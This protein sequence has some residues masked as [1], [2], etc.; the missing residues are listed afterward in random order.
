MT[1]LDKKEKNIKMLK[2]IMVIFFIFVICLSN[3]FG[4]TYSNLDEI[5]N[6]NFARN[7]ANGLI[8]YKD[9]NMIQTPLLS[10]ICGGF[11]KIFGQEIIVMRI[12]ATIVLT[13]IFFLAFKILKKVTN[14]KIALLGVMMFLFLFK[15]ILCIDYNYAVLL[16]ALILVY[17]EILQKEDYFFKHRFKYD[18]IIGMIAGIAVLF[19]Q[20]TGIAVF[21]ACIGYKIFKIRK[22]EEIQDFFKIAI[23]RLIGGLIP[24]IGFV[25]YLVLNEALEDFINYAI[26]GTTTFSN[27]ILYKNLFGQGIISW[28]ALF[29][30]ITIFSMFIIM[31]MKNT[32]REVYIFFAYGI[33][34][35]IVIYPISDK[36][37]FCIGG[38]ITF[39]A[40]IYILFDLIYSE[41]MFSSWNS[42]VRVG[43]Y[44]IFSFAVMFV[45]LTN[46][47]GALKIFD[48]KYIKVNKEKELTHFK[49]IPESIDLK[50]RIFEIND[51]IKEKKELGKN[52]YVLDA[53]AAIYMIPFDRYN[54]NYDMFLKG[55]LGKDGEKGIIEKIKKEENNIYLIKKGNRNW[56]TPNEVC[57]YV[58]ENCEYIGDISIFWSFQK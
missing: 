33:A 39:I 56:Q 24:I 16:V 49:Y 32:S 58:V 27:K 45:L 10:I 31:F 36:I 30:P 57:S 43:L 14:N 26:L 18:F 50:E 37:H 12:I 1:K 44:G 38:L 6:F 41:N 52:V 21:L 13:I 25:I 48:E 8:P 53:E 9:F 15:D 19:K 5:W 4:N 35:S 55:N 42:K 51:Y 11:L 7:I 2:D 3:I 54:K 46:L 34:S 28:L 17:I 47:F 23:T 29:L 40:M 20:T 22:K